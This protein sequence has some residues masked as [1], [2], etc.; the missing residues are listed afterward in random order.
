[1]SIAVFISNGFVRSSFGD[2]LVVMLIY[3]FVKTIFNEKPLYVA[4]GVLM[5]AYLIEFFQL[6][7]IL[8]ILN[9]QNHKLLAIVLGNTFQISDLVSY[10][11]GIVTILILE[12]K[13]R[14]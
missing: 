11:L 10:T 3:C 13:F 8:K 4:I 7:Q 5:F 12:F 2:F 9:L 14:K 1:M 6:F